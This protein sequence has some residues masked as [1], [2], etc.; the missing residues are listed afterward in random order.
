MGVP[1]IQACLLPSLAKAG[2]GQS[3][4]EEQRGFLP[5]G[6]GADGEGEEGWA[7]PHLPC[8]HSGERGPDSS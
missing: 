6:H 7:L 1:E 3:P 2:E 5:S 8:H 4:F